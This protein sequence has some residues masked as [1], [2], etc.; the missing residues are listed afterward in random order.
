M[1]FGLDAHR[2]WVSIVTDLRTARFDRPK[3]PDQDIVVMAQPQYNP[4]ATVQARFSF[5]RLA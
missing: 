1:K 4:P 5:G 2:L 3:N